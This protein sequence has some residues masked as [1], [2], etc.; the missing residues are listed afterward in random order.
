MKDDHFRADYADLTPDQILSSLESLG[1]VTDGRI[2]ALNS[3]ENRVYQIGIEDTEPLIAKFY[4]PGRWSDEQIQEEHDFC[5][6]LNENDLPV[7]PPLVIQ[8]KSLH[9]FEGYRL[10]LFL[11]RGGR[12]GDM[13]NPENLS[14]LGRYLGRMHMVGAASDFHFRPKIDIR[15][16][17]EDSVAFLADKFIPNSLSESYESLV[18]DILELIRARMNEAGDVPFIRCHGDCHAGN[19]LWREGEPNFVDFDDARMAPAI[20]DL[21]MLL[22]GSREEQEGQLAMVVDAYEQFGSFD[23]RQLNLIEPLRTLRIMHHAAWLARRWDDPAFPMAFPWFN[24][25]RYW[26]QHIL[27]LREQMSA[28][29]ETPLRLI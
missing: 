14:Q 15:T 13:D 10:S 11:R 26:G 1:L 4:R 12:E 17:G 22:S 23:D 27:E 20:Q 29:Q 3:Y 7:V 19:I 16:Y 9:C 28:L 18:G 25:E 6:E 2:L 5:F 8:G 24:T 21:W